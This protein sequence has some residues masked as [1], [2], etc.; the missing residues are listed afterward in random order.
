MHSTVLLQAQNCLAPPPGLVH[1]WRAEGNGF[2]TISIQDAV[3]IGGVQF[4]P[5]KVGTAFSFSGS[6][7]DYIALPANIFP[8]PAPG[9]GTP[10]FSFEFWFQTT[11]GGV[12]LGQQDLPPFNSDLGGYV[13]AIYVGTNG[14]LYVQMFWG[15]TAQI[16]STNPVNDAAFHHVA[17]TYDGAVEKLYLDAALIGAEAFAQQGYS[18]LYY[19][20]LGTGYTG[21]WDGT[22]GDWF[23]FTGILDEPSLYNRP[24]SAIEV[25]A[26][27]NSGAAGKCAP[28]GAGLVLR[29]RYSFDSPP[30]SLVITDSIRG[31]NGVLVFGSPEAPYTNGIPDGSGFSGEGTL[32]LNGSNGCVSLPP[33]LLSSLSNFT[34]EAWVTWNGPITSVWQRVFDF[35]ISDRGTNA[36]GIGTNYVIF[37]PGRGGNGL[38]GFEET[39]VNPFGTVID[40]E[41]LVLTGSNPMPIGQEIYIAITYDPPG[42]STRLYFDGALVASSS[43]VVNAT[44]SFM[45]YTDW[46]GRSQW[47]RDP[48][49]NGSYDEFRIW[50]GILTDQDIASHFAV[51]PDQQFVTTRPALAISSVANGVLLTWPADGTASL[52]LQ[53]T[54][55]LSTPSSWAA[56]TNSST[57]S[58]GHFSVLLPFSTGSA[59]YRLAQ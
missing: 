8:L 18:S 24:L 35:G 43:N 40:P 36:N 33:R 5:G 27:F 56:V 13:P 28:P 12:I 29:H 31:A 39:T 34:L 17:V 16:V 44:S 38:P 59:F 32:E 45:D 2:D 3:L 46:L 57:L 37:T 6:G 41:A 9:N 54:G 52:Q 51:G 53:T 30:S 7:D 22:T 25:A 11:N 10:A 49:F 14:L 23:P 58:N 26:L 21:G 4:A 47:D 50:D 15:A 20:E 48:F 1:W 42:N 55:N 19:Y